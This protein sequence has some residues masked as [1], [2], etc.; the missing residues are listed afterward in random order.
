MLGHL[1]PFGAR[2]RRLARLPQPDFFG[3]KAERVELSPAETMRF[4][5][6]L[7]LPGQVERI[8]DTVFSS[9]SETIHVLTRTEVAH[10]GPTLAW[11]L[12]HVD[13]IDGVLYH[14]GGEYHLRPRQRR[15]GLARRPQATASGAL[16][17]TWTSNRW[18]GSWLMDAPLTYDLALAEGVPLTTDA[19]KPQGH[20][21][22]YQELLDI[23][24][25][26]VA[27]DVHF[28]EL[29]LFDDTPNN[30]G[31]AAR[32]RRLRARLLDGRD[33][34]P[35]PGVFLLRG[36]SGDE[37]LLENEM[38]LA[39]RLAATQNFRVIDPMQA[40]VDE[41]V[42]A[43]GGARCI[44]GVEGSHLVH[45]ITVAPDGAA[46][47]PIQPPQRVAATLKL[48]TD[49]LDQRFGLLVAEGGDTRFRL[50]WDDLARTIDLF[51]A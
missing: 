18:F 20:R 15:M 19:A 50:A 42:E 48:M 26:P 25:K 43:C 1:R 32:A 37:R 51:D 45:G 30:S 35:L 46:I 27:G 3:G 14:A 8:A 13:L 5:P 24:P 44:V 31:K 10:E 40:S 16:F 41:L 29:T 28:P 2:L 38:E 9:K 6:A 17:E 11:H 33:I 39:E 23:W 49:R 36:T 7:S 21:R 47:I 22:R 4:P 12:R 34:A